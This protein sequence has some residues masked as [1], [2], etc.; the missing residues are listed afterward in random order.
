[1]SRLLKNSWLGWLL[2]VLHTTWIAMVF[3]VVP[4]AIERGEISAANVWGIQF[5]LDF[6]VSLLMD[7]L[8]RFL[9]ITC[10]SADSSWFV[11]HHVPYAISALSLG[12]FQYFLIGA[13]LQAGVTFVYHLVRSGKSSGME[14]LD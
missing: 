7:P 5:W 8:Q 2:L 10:V 6:P 13:G 12:G 9:E 14:S 1:M 11:S 3:L 4:R